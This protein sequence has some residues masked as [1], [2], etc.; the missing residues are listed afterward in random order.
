MN[1]SKILNQSCGQKKETNLD[2]KKT[3]KEGSSC[4]CVCFRER[5]S[6]CVGE[7]ECVWGRVGGKAI[8]IAGFYWSVM[9]TLA[10]IRTLEVDE[11]RTVFVIK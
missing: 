7:R 10:E 8:A 11:R 2:I 4:T 9:D 1:Y 6:V 3:N 5:E